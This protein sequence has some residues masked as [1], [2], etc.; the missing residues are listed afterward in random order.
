[1]HGKGN[2]KWQDG[3]SYDGEY[4]DDKKHGKG[5]FIWA[6]GRKY[7]GYWNKGKQ[8]GIGIYFLS[9][10]EQKVGEWKDGER[11]RWLSEEEIEKLKKNILIILTL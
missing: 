8:D 11:N 9:A 4:M 5:T 2:I 6:D 1:M 7:I 3:K 10:G